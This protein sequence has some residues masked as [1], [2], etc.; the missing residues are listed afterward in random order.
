MYKNGYYVEKD[1]KEAFYIYTHC[2]EQMTE[3]CAELIGADICMRMGN[4]YFYGIGTEKN[5][6]TAL[7]YYQEAEQHYYRKIRNGDF[8][9]KKGLEGV[10]EKQNEIRKILLDELPDFN[11]RE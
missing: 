9:A 8:F 11:W 2:Y 10:I 7:K 3:V 6:E 4:V 1:E 5:Y